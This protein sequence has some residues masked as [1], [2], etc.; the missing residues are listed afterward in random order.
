MRSVLLLIGPTAV[1]KSAIAVEVAE[2]VG[3][4]I[5][6]AD[7]RAIFRGLEIGT[8]RPPPQIL[9]RVPHHLI[10]ALNPAERY[11]AAAFRADCER[12]VAEI[13][14]RGRRTIVVGGSTLY[15]RALTRGLFPGP[16]A[17]PHLR[18][19]LA[20]RSLAALR[21]ELAQVDPPSAAR[22]HPADRVRLI[23]A[24]EVVRLTGRPLSSSWGEEQPF[25]F[26]LVKIGIALDRGE[27]H[28]RIEARVSRMLAAGLI[29]E[30]RRLWERGIPPNAPAARTI[31]YRELFAYFRGELDLGEAER[32]IVRNTKTYARRQLAFF[33][34]E[35]DVHWLD[36][37]GRTAAEVAEEA[38]AHWRAA[39]ASLESIP[40]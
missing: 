9:S 8:D 17:D 34:A 26:P 27:L 11:D 35:A 14:A 31:G 32:K 29:E 19:E 23:R 39:E 15:V 1:G 5:I 18:E 2:R 4:E 30:A 33:R 10:G 16:A 24:L 38:I 36:G 12:L 28:R 40:C 21:E 13:H 22:I 20:H 25:P 37:T 6:S 7:A 3:A